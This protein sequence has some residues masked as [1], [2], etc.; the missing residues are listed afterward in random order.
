MSTYVDKQSNNC[1]IFEIGDE[2]EFEVARGTNYARWDYMRVEN[3]NIDRGASGLWA[4]GIVVDAE[5]VLGTW[6]KITAQDI[7]YMNTQYIYVKFEIHG[8][9]GAG[10]AG[11]PKKGNVNYLEWQWSRPGFLKKIKVPTC[12]CGSEKVYGKS[13]KLHSFWCEKF[14]GERN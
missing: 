13:T 2:V 9:V 1:P 7:E 5:E 3:V 14:Q 11:F 4:K 8:L 12:V 10:F 6:P